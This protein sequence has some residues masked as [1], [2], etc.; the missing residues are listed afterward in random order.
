MS[1]P[2]LSCLT[3][4][5][6]LANCACPCLEQTAPEGW[7]TSTSG[8]FLGDLIPLNMADSGHSCDDVANPWNV[9]AAGRRA[10]G[11]M[12]MADFRSRLGKRTTKRRE[13]Y[14]GRIGEDAAREIVTP[15]GTYAGARIPTA[16]IKGGYLT[17]TKFGGVFSANGSI[18]VQI[19]DRY[20]RAISTPI[21]ITTVANTLSETITARVL[22]LWTESGQRAEYFAVYTVNP[23]NLPKAIRV[24]CPCGGTACPTFNTANPYWTGGDQH[25][26][27]WM[28]WIGVGPWSGDTL[29]DFDLEAEK[30]LLSSTG[31]T[32]GLT[33]QIELTCDATSVVCLGGMDYGNEATLSAA[34]A[35]YYACAIQTAG[36]LLRN[37][38]AFRSAAVTAEMLA[39]WIT[40]WQE[41]YEKALD[42]ATYNADLTQTDCVFCKS[43]FT[44]TVE[45]KTP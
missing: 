20:N 34:F 7:N 13:T 14:K 17:I 16:N 15:T 45:G 38:E 28:N 5:I 6:G 33:M 36:M 39:A 31:Y 1:A 9:L 44:L 10:G 41:K 42:F 37:T 26:Y 23:A 3:G 30:N 18:S 27:K 19:Y 32:N 4:V 8:L 2:D 12:F 35:Y 22:P 40:V 43:A 24:Y 11:P 29:T 21:V 25:R